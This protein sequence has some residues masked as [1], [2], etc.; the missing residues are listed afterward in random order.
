MKASFAAISGVLVAISGVV[1]IVTTLLGTGLLNP[2]VSTAS[3][4]AS[5]LIGGLVAVAAA[6]A[7]A[8]FAGRSAR[9]QRERIR[10]APSIE[11]RLE[12][13]TS[14]LREVSDVMSG[15]ER[16]LRTRQA[17]LEALSAE[18]KQAQKLASINQEAAEA[19]RQELAVVVKGEGRRSFWLS[20]VVTAV[21][22]LTIG[23][24]A[25]VAAILVVQ[26]WH[27]VGALTGAVAS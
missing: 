27:L 10:S 4:A 12:R 21:I 16:E 6:G 3:T 11:T 15:V 2:T 25:G 19:I 26:H 5:A 24:V 22:T 23:V 7:T 8:V 17:R 9:A 1:A 14:A 18:Y 20:I 13:A